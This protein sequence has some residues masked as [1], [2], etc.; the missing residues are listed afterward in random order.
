MAYTIEEIILS[1]QNHFCGFDT[2]IEEDEFNEWVETHH[3]NL[4][5][6]CG[7]TRFVVWDESWD[8]VLKMNL[9]ADYD[10]VDYCKLEVSNYADACAI[11]IEKILLETRKIAEIGNGDCIYTQPR[12]DSDYARLSSDQKQRLEKITRKIV[13]CEIFNKSKKH[14]HDGYRISDIW[15]A[16]AYQLYGK[17]FMKRFEQWTTT[18]K[19]GD[20]HRHNVGFFNGQPILLDYAGYYGNRARR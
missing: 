16:R 18:L 13:R 11:G 2:G 1:L 5:S 6:S 14:C 15:Y 20:L 10:E 3:P 17:Q 12:Y 8:S 19:I 4:R 9:S 7:A